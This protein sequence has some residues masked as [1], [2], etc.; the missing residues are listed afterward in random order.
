MQNQGQDK[1]QQAFADLEPLSSTDGSFL[2]SSLQ[3]QQQREHMRT[4]VLQDLDKVNLRLKSAKTKVSVRESN[5]SLQLRATLPIKPGDKDTNGTGRKQYNLSLNIPANL[6]G[7]KTAEEEAYELGKL[8]ARKT[9]EWNDKYLGKEATKKDSQT[10]GDLLEKFAEEYFKTHKRTTKSEHTFFYYFSRTQR[11]TNSKDLATAENLINSIEQIDKEWARYN[12]ARAISAFCITFNIEID[13][14]QYSKMP[15]RNSRN[16]PT[17]AEI[18]SGITKFE[19]YLVTRGN[20]VNEDVKDSWQLWRWTYGMLAV[21]GLRPREI[22]INPNIDWWLSKENIDLTWK[23]D[24]ECKTGERQA[25]P[26]HKEWIDEFDLRNPKYLEM[27]AT[28]ISKKDKTNHAE[29]TALTQRISWWFR[30]VEL[31]FKPYDLR[32]AW[33]IRAH[34]LGI[35]IK[36]AADNLGHSMQVHTQTYQRWF[37]LDMRKLAINQALTKRNE[38]E[39]IREENAKLQIENERLR[40]EI[41]KLKM[42]IAYKNS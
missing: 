30:K 3:A 29:I 38:F 19:D 36:A 37:S 23:V 22:F 6:D 9:F 34:I 25:L 15:D 27:L 13:L 41:E 10:I 12:A 17:D 8:I 39:V 32:H 35:P 20:Q 24:K 7:L 2:G 31:D 40:M 16:I 1:Y 21:F 18:L 11:Y 33:A 4:K 5:G 28:A 26:L 42:E 14:S